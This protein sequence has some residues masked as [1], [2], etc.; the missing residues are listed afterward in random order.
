M[1][2]ESLS[3]LERQQKILL[4]LHERPR[5]TVH[6]ICQIFSISEATA[7]RDLD[8]L[9]EQNFI[10]R[11]HGGAI[12]VGNISPTLPMVQR[13]AREAEEKKRIGIAAAKLIKDGET[14][15][16][17]SGTTVY[18]VAKE[19]REKKGLTVVTNSLRVLNLLSGLGSISLVALGGFF[20][21]RELAFIG[22]ITQLA[23]AEIRADKV[24]MGIHAIHIEH[25]L[26]NDYLPETLT[27]RAILRGGNELILV[28]DHTKINSIST[29]F[30][31]PVTN[32]DTFVTGQEAPADFVSS[33]RE[34]GVQVVLA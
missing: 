23:M 19:L 5:I 20:W 33:L 7:R 16:L 31:I 25:G 15:F 4:F 34:M 18:A 29:A 13:D 28:A 3:A 6:E 17:G 22:H 27:D 1:A 12:A 30:L 2:F 9:R 14:V 32:I 8:S 11:V 21:E 24:V 10:R 26:T